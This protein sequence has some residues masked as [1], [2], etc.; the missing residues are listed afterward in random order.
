MIS[1]AAITPVANAVMV[2]ALGR[3]ALLAWIAWLE[4]TER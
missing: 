4:M 3:Y 2:I 1:P